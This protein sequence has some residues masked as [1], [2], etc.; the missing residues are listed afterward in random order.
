MRRELAR[1]VFLAVLV[2]SL[3]LAST[4]SAHPPWERGAPPRDAIRPEIRMRMNEDGRAGTRDAR[5]VARPETFRGEKPRPNDSFGRNEHKFQAPLK[6]EI[7]NK[8]ADANKKPMPAS[9]KTEPTAKP[10]SDAFGRNEHKFQ[11]PLKPEIALKL[12]AAGKSVDSDKMIKRA[13]PQRE[14]VKGM[15]HITSRP[16]GNYFGRR[17][18][19]APPVKPEIAI[20]MQGP[21][22]NLD[23]KPGHNLLSQRNGASKPSL[24]A[25]RKGERRAPVQTRPKTRNNFDRSAPRI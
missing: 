3:A 15:G 25:A 8:L 23:V 11:L 18:H 14:S 9:L 12:E 2:G 13:L 6:P 1:S 20:K 4:A 24:G 5:A 19:F 7:A 10:A 22:Q 17:H 21:N 16:A